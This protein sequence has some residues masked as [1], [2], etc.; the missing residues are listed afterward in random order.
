L[1]EHGAAA[2]TTTV[3]SG[4][5]SVDP[6]AGTARALTESDLKTVIAACW[7]D[8]GDPNLV[9]VGSTDKQRVSAF[10][11]IATQYRDN[12]QVGPGVIVASADVYVSTWHRAGVTLH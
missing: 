12:P 5:P 6:V 4:A 11:G 1:N 8:G 2:S 3:T 7:T 10:S 9:L